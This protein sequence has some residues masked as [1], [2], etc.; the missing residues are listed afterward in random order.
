M[1]WGIL[2]V[3]VAVLLAEPARAL[4]HSPRR[5]RASGS[6]EA[7]AHDCY[8]P[9][10]GKPLVQFMKC[11]RAPEMQSTVEDGSC[12]CL[13]PV[14][15]CCLHSRAICSPESVTRM[16]MAAASAVQVIHNDAGGF[17]RNLSGN[18]RPF[19]SVPVL[20]SVAPDMAFYDHWRGLTD[21]HARI[22]AAVDRTPIARLAVAGTSVEDRTIWAV[23]FTG[24]NFVPG[25]GL[26]VLLTFGVHAREWV[27]GMSATF[28][29]EKI[30]QR[31]EKDPG[32]LAE[33]E[34][35]VLPMVNPDGFVFSERND[36]LWRKNK[37]DNGVGNSRGFRTCQGVDLNRNFPV[38]WGGEGSTSKS[39]CSEVY[40][41]PGPA[42]EPETQAVMGVVDEGHV[43]LHIDYH[44]YSQLIMAPWSYRMEPH[45]DRAELDE[46]M[47]AMVAAIKS[48]TGKS[49]DAGGS[50]I[51]YPAS[52]IGPD[53]ATEKGGW[54]LTVELP[55][56]NDMTGGGFMLPE[57]DI[58]DSARLTFASVLAAY[59]W[60]KGKGYPARKRQQQGAP[61]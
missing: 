22:T 27:S 50:E 8:S 14:D 54:G 61:P 12:T 3:A 52:G 34:I 55:P 25:S 60:M 41:G 24:A 5:G 57:D 36:R 48:R 1:R 2:P 32:W 40:I 56:K 42:S 43:D 46:L 33:D 28:V 11:A 4:S 58:A 9:Y 26:K 7:P 44:S 31:L 59:D 51:L 18:V 19:E 29:I 15:E 23:R 49:F 10:D 53:Y 13:S 21:Q 20:G 45:V 6:P 30:A 17:Y 39:F 35:V 47:A 38:D 37:H 16:S